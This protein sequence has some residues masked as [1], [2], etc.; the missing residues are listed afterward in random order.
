M[1]LPEDFVTSMTSYFDDHPELPRE[2][3]FESFDLA[4]YRGI[5]MNRLKVCPEDDGKILHALGNSI[6][7]VPWCKS[8]YYADEKISGND[9]YF[10]AGV[11]YL[12]EPS[13]ML[14]A[15]VL[16]AK[17]GER[18]LDLCA[19]PGG[20]ATRI[21]ESMKGQGIF[22]A[23]D[24]SYDRT[25]ALLRNIER[26]GIENAVILS[27][28]PK[29][30]ATRFPLFFD[31]ILID[32]PCSGEGMFRRDLSAIR[33]WEKFGTSTTTTMQREILSRADEMLRPG[34]S[35]I[36]S[37]CTFSREE[38]EGMIEWFIGEHR[39]YKVLESPDIQG[40][41]V[42]SSLGLTKGSI[43]IW[44]HTSKGDGH[45]CVR[46]QKT[47]E[48]KSANPE[49][50]SKFSAENS[51]PRGS[52]SKAIKSME[53]FF[54]GILTDEAYGLF[55]EKIN[56]GTVLLGDKIHF[57]PLIPSFY[58]GLKMIKM[59]GFPGELI[60]KGSELIF[61]PSQSLALS[62]RKEQIRPV[63]FLSFDRSDE[64]LNRYLKG[65]T[66]FLNEHEMV[67]LEEGR[68]LIIAVDGFPL[69]FAKR[70]AATLKNLY[71]KSWRV[72]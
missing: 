10:H 8:G 30:L 40:V 26:L 69:G 62:L 27:E 67:I 24:I 71:P 28:S 58:D 29:R 66:V 50:W 51:V 20:K 41:S 61:S 19:A 3:F 33:S 64:R 21:A 48:E 13:A 25:K 52:L 57:H 44:P 43:R 18:I 65:E 46:L 68:F 5:R 45:F 59:G 39:Q 2:G 56:A 63:R 14:P 17:P 9:P 6:E 49:E 36:Y 35:I 37:T 22:I 32:A 38:D 15:E 42:N 72:L 1:K 4:S 7:N 16:S 53:L 70:T 12:Q 11:F 60:S 54:S 47:S 34:G 31:K 23:N 55:L